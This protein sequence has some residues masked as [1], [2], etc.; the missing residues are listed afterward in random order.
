MCVYNMFEKSH[1]KICKNL[2]KKLQNFTS[3]IIYGLAVY[4]YH[5]T[6]NKKRLFNTV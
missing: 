6:E 2:S 5:K 3:I 4:F 1:E